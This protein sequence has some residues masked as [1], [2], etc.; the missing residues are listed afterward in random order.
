MC[1]RPQ[2]PPEKK[3]SYPLRL[4]RCSACCLLLLYAHFLPRVETCVDL[5][6]YV[7]GCSTCVR[8]APLSFCNAARIHSTHTSAPPS[9]PHPAFAPTLSRPLFTCSARFSAPFCEVLISLHPSRRASSRLRGA[10]AC[11]RTPCAHPPSRVTTPGH[12]APG[13]SWAARACERSVARARV[14]GPAKL[15]HYPPFCPLVL[16]VAN[17]KPYPYLAPFLLE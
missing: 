8:S 6:R 4:G 2:P 5:E 1:G 11:A 7:R 3:T 14:G 17:G 15:R 9:L 10:R 16:I 12:V 13:R